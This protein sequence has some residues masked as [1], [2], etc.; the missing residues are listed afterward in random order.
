MEESGK[1]SHLKEGVL[2]SR[3]KKKLNVVLTPEKN[4]SISPGLISSGAKTLIKKYVSTRWI[5]ASVHLQASCKPQNAA[6]ETH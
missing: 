4:H 5:S 6:G 3:F 2:T 1:H